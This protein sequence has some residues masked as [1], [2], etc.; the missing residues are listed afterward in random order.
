MIKKIKYLAIL[1]F[2]ANTAFASGG[3]VYT[4]YGIGEP[5][6]YYSASKMGLSALGIAYSD[7]FSINGNNP[8]SW[9]SINLT[10][11][12]ASVL[13]NGSAI[14]NLNTSGKSHYTTFNG[15]ALAV[16]IYSR[17]G[18]VSSLGIIPYSR[19]DY[20]VRFES[21]DKDLG[22]FSESFTGDGG[23]SKLYIGS[24]VKFSDWAF[25]ATFEYYIGKIEY[26]SNLVFPD[27][28]SFRNV[29]YVL[30]KNYYGVGFTLG[31][32]TPDLSKFFKWN[33]ISDF[34][35]GFLLNA[36]PSIKTDSTVSTNNLIGTNQIAN[37]LTL[38]KLP[39]KI[40]VGFSFILKQKFR[41][42]FDFVT[43]NWS[44][45]RFADARGKFLN[46]S[47]RA[48]IGVE[49]ARPTN[50]F[51]SFKEQLRYRVGLSYEKLPFVI[52]GET[53]NQVAISA[54]VS[55][56]LGFGNSIDIGLTGGIRGKKDSNIFEEKFIGASVAFSLGELWFVRIKR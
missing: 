28:S 51:S 8:A 33:D 25:G 19:V 45:Y 27:T 6:Y 39:L 29:G 48:A 15:F 32:I 7:P 16:P 22:D 42:A 44:D 37:G 56:P 14:A 2:L 3:G 20:K 53:I 9:Y 30:H 47:F 50:R 40:G 52:N 38:T 1:L 31:V 11:M 34:R 24:S 12:E 10:R 41:I 18:I 13:F 49:Y 46:R 55:V 21:S 54:G 23:L 4:R 36:A 26:H 5:V 17:L 43:Q 35:F